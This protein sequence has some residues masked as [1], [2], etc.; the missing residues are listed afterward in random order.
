MCVEVNYR[1]SDRYRYGHLSPSLNLRV[2]RK[3]VYKLCDSGD[4]LYSL[5]YDGRW[6][7]AVINQDG[8][9]ALQID[10][11][12]WRSRFFGSIGDKVPWWEQVVNS[13]DKTTVI[14]GIIYPISYEGKKITGE[15]KNTVNSIIHKSPKNAIAVQHVTPLVWYVFDVLCYE[16]ECLLQIPMAE[17][18][19]YIQKVV[20]KIN[21]PRVIGAQYKPI[22]SARIFEKDY[23]EAL[24]N[25]ARGA[26]LYHRQMEYG[27]P[28]FSHRPVYVNAFSQGRIDTVVLTRPLKRRF[29]AMIMG[30]APP[31]KEYQGED[32]TYHSYWQ[33]LKTGELLSGYYSGQYNSGVLNLIPI[34]EEYYFQKPG[35][36]KIGVFSKDKKLIHIGTARN[37]PPQIIQMMK[38]EP[39][40]IKNVPVIATATRITLK[41]NDEI[42]FRNL[43]LIKFNELYS[44]KICTMDQFLEQCDVHKEDKNGRR[45]A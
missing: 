4:Y 35:G 24:E 2:Y 12:N 26:I 37:A 7:R 34:T 44:R 40:Y 29:Y 39:N 45:N 15:M 25:G 42:E 27:K 31:V 23:T 36:V 32:L 8:F 11:S 13:F 10:V 18:V 3:N 14:L 38:T 41:P 28:I 17:R 43:R 6:S 5:K 22:L 30:V 20:E 19:K 1:G 21:H 16:G 33:N 9:T